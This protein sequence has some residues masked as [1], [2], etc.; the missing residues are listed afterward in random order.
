M[1]DETRQSTVTTRPSAGSR[2]GKRAVDFF[3]LISA[4]GAFLAAS[5]CVLPF[6]F[7]AAGLGGSWLAFL[8]DGLLYRQELQWIAGAVLGS[9]WLLAFSDRRRWTM[10]R[11]ALLI[12]TLLLIASILVWE[13]QGQLREWLMNLR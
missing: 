3:S 2:P 7:I 1:I 4:T 6:L 12:A 11:R 10:H 9:G 5:C 13:F 8:D